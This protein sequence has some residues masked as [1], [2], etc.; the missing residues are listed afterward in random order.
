MDKEL[1][2]FIDLIEKYG[3]CHVLA[4]IDPFHYKL[5][6]EYN[7]TLLAEEKFENLELKDGDT[8]SFTVEMILR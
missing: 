8:F 3:L 7:S 6:N 1:R 2:E 4:Q 5:S